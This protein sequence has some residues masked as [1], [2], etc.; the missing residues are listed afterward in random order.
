MCPAWSSTVNVHEG[1]AVK[2]G[3][4]LF[5]LDLLPFRIA[6]DSATANLHGT[7]LTTESMKT[8]YKVT[9]SNVDAQQ[10]QVQPASLH[11][12]VPGD[13]LHPPLIRVNGDS[14]DIHRQLSR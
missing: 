6:L 10:S 13:L 9:L 14:G 12:H 5:Q 2:A 8:D 3:D 1:Q 4:L 7:A 11:G